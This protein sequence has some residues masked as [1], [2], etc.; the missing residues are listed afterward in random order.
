MDIVLEK[1]TLS[2]LNRDKAEDLNRLTTSKE[3]KSVIQKLP[4]KTEVQDHKASLL[5]STNHSKK[6]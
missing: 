4:K 2:R 6:H 3:I 1:C 5:N